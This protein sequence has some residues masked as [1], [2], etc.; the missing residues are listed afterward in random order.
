MPKQTLYITGVPGLTE[1]YHPQLAYSQVMLVAREGKLLVE[2]SSTPTGKRFRHDS[3]AAKI[4]L[5][6][7]LPILIGGTPPP[8]PGPVVSGTPEEFIIEIKY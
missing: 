8:S 2:T 6:E 1:V 5:P 7:D 4:L 3:A